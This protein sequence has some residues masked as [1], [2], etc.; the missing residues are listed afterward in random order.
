MPVFTIRWER[1]YELAVVAESDDAARDA[2]E[3]TSGYDLNEWSDDGT[4][5][6]LVGVAWRGDPKTD[7][8]AYGGRIVNLADVPRG[9]REEI[10]AKARAAA[11]VAHDEARQVPLF[12]AKAGA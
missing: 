9:W 11:V 10:G 7:Q 6:E 5:W 2:A 3:A 8:A 4:D 1:T 12:G